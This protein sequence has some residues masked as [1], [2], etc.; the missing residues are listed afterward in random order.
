MKKIIIILIFFFSCT[1]CVNHKII[2]EAEN[3]GFTADEMAFDIKNVKDYIK[4]DSLSGKAVLYIMITDEPRIK[5]FN[6]ICL[7]LSNKNGRE[8]VKYQKILH[9]PLEINDYPQEVRSYY[10]IF[11]NY[12]DSLYIERKPGMHIDNSRAYLRIKIGGR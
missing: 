3:P 10:S 5:Y 2:K 1:C 9:D 4:I 7:N 12:V 11:K 6:I 8:I